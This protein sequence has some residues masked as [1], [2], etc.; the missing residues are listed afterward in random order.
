M[1]TRIDAK[2]GAENT[3]KGKIAATY[4]QWEQK[5]IDAILENPYAAQSI[6]K[7]F[8]ITDSKTQDNFDFSYLKPIEDR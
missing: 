4:K 2:Q 5:Q 8:V 6:L 3:E 1:I 7:D